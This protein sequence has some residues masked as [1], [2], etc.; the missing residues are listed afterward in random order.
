MSKGR[1]IT[2]REES[3]L[4]RAL[5]Q[6]RCIPG[7]ELTHEDIGAWWGC[8]RQRIQQ[9]EAGALRKIRNRL[10]HTSPDNLPS[11]GWGS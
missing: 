10:R 11:L 2:S 6:R 3:D 1:R 5:L 4:G 7:Q 9:Y 8:S